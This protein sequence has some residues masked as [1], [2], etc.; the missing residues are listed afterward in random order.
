MG[1]LLHQ[2]PLDQRNCYETLRQ[3]SHAT[4]RLTSEGTRQRL[5]REKIGTEESFT[6]HAV[7]LHRHFKIWEEIEGIP[8]MEDLEEAVQIEQLFR[9]LLEK[10]LPFTSGCR[11]AMLFESAKLLK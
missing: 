9:S 5:Q 6:S 11:K 4:S 2:L 3:L 10:M 7:K 8:T 1:E